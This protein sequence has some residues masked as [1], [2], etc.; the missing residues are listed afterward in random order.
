MDINVTAISMLITLPVCTS[1]EDTQETTQED[2][3]IQKLKIYT[4]QGWSHHK[5][6]VEHSMKHFWPVRSEPAMI[7]CTT[8][9][10]RRL[11]IPFLL[12]KQILEQLHSNHV[13]LRRL[14]L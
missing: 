3:H 5:D 9:K 6:E 13:V 11:I 4:I 8:M 7:D 1:I 12:Q 2:A 10:S 14:D